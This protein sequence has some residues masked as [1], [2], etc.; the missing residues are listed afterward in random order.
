[1]IRS[2]VAVL[3]IGASGFLFFNVTMPQYESLAELKTQKASLN[4]ALQK[5]TELQ[6]TRD[7]LLSKYN[8]ISVISRERLNK[9]MPLEISGVNLVAQIFDMAQSRRLAL[10]GID[11]EE[12]KEKGSIAKSMESKSKPFNTVSV[13]F[14]VSGTYE[15]FLTFLGDLEKSLQIVDVNDLGFS[16]N[17]TGVYDFSVKALTYYYAGK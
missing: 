5:S 15:D 7:E 9:A 17:D 13:V 1:M 16:A 8:S 3:I 12:Q 6:K 14:K 4:D 10:K 11:I 2:L